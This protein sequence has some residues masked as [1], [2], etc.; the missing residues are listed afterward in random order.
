MCDVKHNNSID[1]NHSVRV[2]IDEQIRHRS[3]DLVKNYT[4]C[5]LE[6][7]WP[8]RAFVAGA[9]YDWS[10]FR[11]R[12]DESWRQPMVKH[13]ELVLSVGLSTVR[14]EIAHQ[15]DNDEAFGVIGNSNVKS[16]I[17]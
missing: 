3:Y 9:N 17:V 15:H 11:R 4:G 6:S 8:R 14:K 16:L 7:R 1:T 13:C 5:V 12:S 2:S 10:P